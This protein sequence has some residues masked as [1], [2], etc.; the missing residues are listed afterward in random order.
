MNYLQQAVAYMQQYPQ[1]LAALAGILASWGL[2]ASIESAIPPTLAAWAQKLITFV[3]GFVVSVVV[4]ILVWRGIDPKDAAA[5]QYG[6]SIM[7]ALIAPILYVWVSRALSH[8]FPWLTAWVP[9]G[10]AA[11]PPQQPGAPP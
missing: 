7:A 4:S 3:A 6:I 5:L 2:V 1:I 9:P 10:S 8:F 11:P